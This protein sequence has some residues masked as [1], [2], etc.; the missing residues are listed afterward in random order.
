MGFFKTDI[1][2]MESVA[3]R[4]SFNPTAAI[5]KSDVQSAIEAGFA[6]QAPSDADYL[7]KT[8]SAN[9]SAER[10]VTDTATIA[11]DWATGGQAKAAV[12]DASIT[13][14]KLANVAGLSVMGRSANT[15]GVPADITGTDGQVLRVSGTSLG[16]GTVVAAGIAS[17]AVTTVKILDAAVTYAKIANGTGLSVFG[18][19]A[20]S[21]GVNADIVGTDGQVLRVA[22]TALGFG[23][24][25]AAGIASDAVTT[26]KV[27][28]AN[29]TYAKIQNVA[30]NS[31]IGRAASSS[32]V[33]AAITAGTDQVL[34][35]NGGTL[36]F[37]TVATG[38]IANN[39]VTLAKVAAGTA[40]S[41]LGVTGNAGANYA[42][43]VAGSDGHVMRRS[44]SAIGFGT[45]A[46]AGITDGV[47]TF[48]KL[49]SAA[50][51]TDGTFASAND[52]TLPT[53]QAVKTYVDALAGVL[54]GALIFKGSWDASAG[55]FPGTAGRKTGWFYKVSVAGTVDGQLF[56]VGDDLYALV[57]T[58]ST[59]T[60]AANWLHVEGSIT[61]AEV[62]AAL[63]SASITYAKIQDVA[64][65]SVVGRSANSSGVSAAITGTDGQVLRVAGTALG[66]GTIVAAGLAS[67]AVSTVKILDANVTY[68][69]IANVAGLS[70]MGRSANSSG[71]PAD[72]TG[73]DGNVL[74][75]SGTALGFG[76]IVAAGIASDAVTTV[77][78]L[79]ANVTYAKIA[80]AAAGLSVIGRSANTSG[81]NADIAGTDKQV[82]RVSGTSL[83]FGAIDATSASAITGVLQAACQPV[84]SGAVVNAGGVAATTMTFDIVVAI[85]G[86]S[87][88]ITTG[89]KA[90]NDVHFDFACTIVSITLFGDQTGS[91]VL[92]VWKDTYANYPPTVADTITSGAK[93]T[94]SS[95][96]KAQDA[97]LTGWTKSIASGDVLR[98]NVDSCT[99]TTK[100]VLI[101]KATKTS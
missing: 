52:T 65:L 41:V 44:G 87:S 101:I 4:S 92:D 5:P 55:T 36:G 1:E 11:W 62:I 70:V 99:T 83:G 86:G 61:S 28:D 76:T 96:V 30:G 50:F 23:T 29:I 78:I 49:A 75:V 59:S 79:D 91:I 74:R 81:V 8:A 25:V 46:A 97:T 26:V 43:M 24:I 45:I 7:V 66:F 98:F 67:D 84:L 82:L 100:A 13:Y 22:G 85:D 37:G 33:S 47:I 63:A 38:G 32:G 21:G 31:V 69:K 54:S 56:T 16:F 90:S 93:P 88:A 3:A 53:T 20:N 68:A 89:V 58:A 9:L 95:A 77:K 2:K 94:L 27:L 40:L 18:R 12:V 42:D 34:R 57:D 64:G 14:A 51:S 10:V 6:G 71:V 80:S 39:A 48:A 72:I 60:Y 35:E 17:D 15:S 19:S 73:V